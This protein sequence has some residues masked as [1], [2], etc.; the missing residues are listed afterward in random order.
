MLPNDKHSDRAISRMKSL[1][2]ISVIRVLSLVMLEFIVQELA[3]VPEEL[4]FKAKM[5][6]ITVG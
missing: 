5:L 2:P 6:N 3:L 1:L 4:S